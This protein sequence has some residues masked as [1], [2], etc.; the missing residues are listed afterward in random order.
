MLR[1][2]GGEGAVPADSPS[3]RSVQDP[4]Q[5]LS[6]ARLLMTQITLRPRTIAA[7]LASV[8]AILFLLSL[9]APFLRH[10]LGHEHLYGIV[11][12]TERLFDLDREANVPTWFSSGILLIAAGLLAA[13]GSG[14]RAV[15]PAYTRHWLVLAAIFLLLSLDEAAS[16]HEQFSSIFRKYVTTGGV[17]TYEWVIPASVFVLVVGVSYLRFLF[18]L[19]VATRNLIAAAGALYVL[20]ALGME[21]VEGYFVSASAAYP[22]SGLRVVLTHTQ[23]V[24]EMYGIVLFVYALLDYVEKN[25][26]TVHVSVGERNAPLPAPARATSGTT[27]TLSS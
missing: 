27:T 13:I 7:I 18:S 1:A 12:R 4:A 22:T 5:V 26:G 20:G 9:I 3:I 6:Q 21:M 23:E 25:L 15:R 11:P 10:V 17:L 14:E 19:P 16:F 8:A 24:L 2:G